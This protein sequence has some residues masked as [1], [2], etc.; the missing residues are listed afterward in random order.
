MSNLNDKDFKFDLQLFAEGDGEDGEDGFPTWMSQLPDE[1]KKDEYGK[2]Y[3]T[4]GEFYKTHKGLKAKVDK[5]QA[6]EKASEYEFPEDEKTDKNTLDWFRKTAFSLKLPKEFA[7][8]LY[9]EFNTY[10]S[11]RI[12]K[13][14]EDRAKAI[15]K[16]DE[17]MHGEWGEKFDENMKLVDKA[18][19]DL[20][21][22]EL[23]KV[24]ED[25]GVD[26]NPVVLKA[27]KQIGFEHSEDT[28]KTGTVAGK[29]VTQSGVDLDDEY[30][31]MK[32]M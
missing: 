15:E 20:G 13:M 16:S 25:A 12:A 4:M 29:S 17:L 7:E 3:K 8:K 14:G 28:M 6:P 24:L 1:Y 23:K 21:G 9:G 30:P 11:G 18:Y 2:G 26:T 32:D 19:D 27:L 10:A 5:I 31:S 22:D